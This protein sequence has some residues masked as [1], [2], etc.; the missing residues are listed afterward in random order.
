VVRAVYR[1][2]ALYHGPAV[3]TAPD[4][5]LEPALEDGYSPVCLPT[6]P[7]ERRSVR[8][9][10]PSEHAAGK[11]AGMNGSHRAEG[12]WALAGPGV[13]A[14]TGAAAIVDVAPT[15]LHLAGLPVPAWMDGRLLPGVP[16]AAVLGV[17]DPPALQA[18]AADQGGGELWRRLAALGYLGE[19]AS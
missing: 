19:S 16:G 10:A 12:L 6:R 17:G 2:D 18:A 11:G 14:C 8:R 7:A 13:M 15:V 4:L 1:R 5:L 9:L 3:D